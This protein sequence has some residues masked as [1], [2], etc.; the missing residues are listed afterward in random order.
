MDTHFTFPGQSR[1]LFLIT[2]PNRSD[3]NKYR[4]LIELDLFP[5][6]YKRMLSYV[7]PISLRLSEPLLL[8]LIGF[9]LC[10]R[11][12]YLFSLSSKRITEMDFHL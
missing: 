9:L 1:Y 3:R 2:F 8:P 11:T 5:V 4:Q 10:N 12:E 7:L 6:Y